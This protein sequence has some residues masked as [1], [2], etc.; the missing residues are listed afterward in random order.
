[1]KQVKF[2]IGI[3]GFILVCYLYVY[4]IALTPYEDMVKNTKITE[5][6]FIQGIFYVSYFLIVFFGGYAVGYFYSRLLIKLIK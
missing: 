1:M 4:L 3:I 5:L 6:S 2:V